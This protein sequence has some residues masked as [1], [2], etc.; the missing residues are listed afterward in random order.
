MY[1]TQENNERV[2]IKKE[3]YSIIATKIIQI[4][5]IFYFKG[6]F[7]GKKNMLYQF[8]ILYFTHT[9]THN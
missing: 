3:K 4:D 6:A 8:R 5:L 9:A 7:Y 2:L 1:K